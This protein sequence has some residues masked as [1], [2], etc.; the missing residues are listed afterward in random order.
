MATL[1]RRLLKT[2]QDGAYRN[3]SFCFVFQAAVDDIVYDNGP[4]TYTAAAL[5][6]AVGQFSTSDRQKVLI[7]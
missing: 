1:F 6:T 3:I 2:I 7:L 5:R 4:A